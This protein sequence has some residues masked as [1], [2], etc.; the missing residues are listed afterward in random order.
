MDELTGG[1]KSVHGIEVG[2]TSGDYYLL[3]GDG[4][5]VSSRTRYKRT[6]DSFE[7]IT[8]QNAN[9]Q[10]DVLLIAP[11]ETNIISCNGRGSYACLTVNADTGSLTQFATAN[12]IYTPIS[13]EYFRA[14]ITPS[15]NAIF[16][17]AENMGSVFIIKLSY[18]FTNTQR[19]QIMNIPSANE[20]VTLAA[21]TDNKVFFSH[22]NTDSPKK[23]VHTLYDFS[24]GTTSW[25]KTMACP[26]S[27]CTMNYSKAK[28]SGGYIYNVIGV[29]DIAM[30]II[31]LEIQ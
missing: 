15:N 5:T 18:L 3:L 6:D 20:Y 2:P 25:S 4:S 12:G 13:A 7:F 27:D 19:I 17:F 14:A 26:D 10:A 23:I 28:F 8:S 24:G 31:F 21:P 30:F 16:S 1:T 29:A 9:N 22:R 11:D